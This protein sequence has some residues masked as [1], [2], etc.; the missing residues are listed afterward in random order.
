MHR[1]LPIL[2][3]AAWLSPLGVH[4]ASQLTTGFVKREVFVGIE[5]TS[6]ADLTASPKFNA[7]QPDGVSLLQAF[8][9]PSRSGENYGQR[10]S[11][12]LVPPTTGAYV[13]FIASDDDSELWLSTDQTPQNKQLIAS[14]TG[15]TL[16]RQWNRYPD[17]Q[18]NALA[19]VNLV[20]GRAYYIEAL[21][22]EGSGADH[23]AVGWVLPGQ[24]VDPSADP[25]VG[26]ENIAVI[27]GSALGAM[28]DSANATVTITTPPADVKSSP[29]GQ[30]LFWVKA[31]GS[32]DL[33][34]ALLYQWKRNGV[35]IPG[36]NASGYLTPALTVTDDGAK[37][38]CVVGVPGKSVTSP[39][40]VLTVSDTQ[41]AGLQ[42]AALPPPARK[43]KISWDDPDFG[44]DLL[45]APALG[46]TVSWGPVLEPPVYEGTTARVE[47]EAN[48]NRFFRL[49][50]ET[51]VP[52]SLWSSE[53]RPDADVTGIPGLELGTIFSAKVP[54]LIRSIR[55][56]SLAG[57]YGTHQARLWRVS[58]NSVIGGPYEIPCLGAEGWLTFDLPKA[59]AIEPDVDYVVSVSTAQDPGNV[60]PRSINVLSA[61]GSNDRSL[62]YPAAA[63]VFG[64]QLGA[65]PTQTDRNSL[66]FRDVVF[67][68]G[69]VPAEN[70]ITWALDQPVSLG[71]GGDETDHEF[72]TVFRPTVPG[73]ITAI[74]VFGLA[75]E[76]GAHQAT[77][78]RN[79]DGAMIGGPYEL[80]Y[81]CN[82]QVCGSV[83]VV[84]P[85]E[86]PVGVE[87]NTDYTISVSTGEDVGKAY[88]FV[89]QAF[90]TAGGNGQH[91]TY[92]AGA[93]V[94]GDL[95]SRPTSVDAAKPNYLR[96][97]EF[98]PAGSTTSE[99]LMGG[100][101]VYAGKLSAPHEL[102]TVFQ[103]SI[104]GNIK[105]IRVYTVH[106]ESGTH[107]ARLWRNSD[108][109][110]VGGPYPVSYGGTV[111][112]VEVALPSPVAVEPNVPY[113]V[114]VTTGEDADKAYP[115][116][117][118]GFIS[119]GGNTKHLS[120][121]EKA[122][123]LS[124]NP[125]TRPTQT[126]NANS[127][128]RDV[129]FQPV[130]EN[131][132]ATIGN[133]TDGTFRDYITDGSTTPP[134][135]YIN[136]N[137]F[138][139]SAD[140]TVTTIKAKIENAPGEYKCA[141]YTDRD[142]LGDR[143]L[144][145]SLGKSNPPNGWNEFPLTAP[146]K[147]KAGQLYWL[148]IWSNDKD[149]RVYYSSQTGGRLR[150]KAADYGDWPDPIAMDPNGSEYL[151]CLYAE[152][153]FDAP[154][155]R[156]TIG[157]TTD[158]TFRDYITDAT[159][160]YI[161]ANQYRAPG[162]MTVTAI[163]AKVENAPGEYKCAIYSDKDGLGDRLLAS[164]VGKTNPPNGWNDFPLTAPLQL[165]AGELYW[166]AIW[167]NHK[168]ARVY[169]SSQ[170]GG[171]LRWKASPYGA[172]PDPIEMDPNGTEYLY[173][174]YAE[175][176][177]DD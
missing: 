128:L 4:A 5:G 68:P 73:S 104:A 49:K 64:T 106:A 175:G 89:S 57:E 11:A 129:V 114:S 67:L 78:W 173:C 65:R 126:P 122:G 135:P 77:L 36:A 136:A 61:G 172:W 109:S 72:G 74:R 84:Y 94:S 150:W 164:S 33:G 20:A 60:Y 127:Y 166:L 116:V 96:D 24:A 142:G 98:Q 53:A 146:L 112:W 145:A 174:L 56:Y 97:I 102:G 113:T 18:N 75:A 22:K 101:A 58:D 15:N 37:Y 12:L 85:L 35:D 162:N 167:S 118:D 39:E 86:V 50:H 76:S 8:E 170:T 29:G 95:W 124:P 52:E 25:P 26:L 82:G 3:L 108:N 69:E 141:I 28:I 159:D 107:T 87:A 130:A 70:V 1:P 168:D 14:V 157:N 103:S 140:M 79:S 144:A 115:F 110:V 125:G 54:G 165:K 17:T 171:R 13:F 2:L 176:T 139:A 99:N 143:L 88:P 119:A 81:G 91:L 40:A 62:R 90:G 63:G 105:A 93:G 152:G 120:Y 66:Y 38:S 137:Q 9:A 47:L 177:F 42:I 16:S 117:P 6:V 132:R 41:A 32:S 161:N 149:A 55:F 121:P 80:R 134:T 59:L 147:L 169:Y 156:A 45:G 163:K 151:Y 23:V 31:T 138:K 92:P 158:G 100:G 10:L 46:G 21:A 44:F 30:A 111:G 123:V 51:L 155:P 133:T 27:P 19:P 160:A 154:K 48:Q 83:W 148:A 43:V 34:S 71:R 131:A 153:T 7:S